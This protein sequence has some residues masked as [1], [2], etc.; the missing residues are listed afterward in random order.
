MQIMAGTPVGTVDTIL[1]RGVYMA[2]PIHALR[3]QEMQFITMRYKQTASAM[4]VIQVWEAGATH[5]KT[6]Q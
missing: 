3:T 4:Q 1:T 6:I 2:L 5:G